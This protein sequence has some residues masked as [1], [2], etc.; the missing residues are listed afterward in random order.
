ML[1]RSRHV[2]IVEE[3]VKMP[4]LTAPVLEVDKSIK[5]FYDFTVDS[6]RLV[7]YKFND[8]KYDIPVAE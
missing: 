4:R 7:D 3:I 6:F 8:K 5:N 2:P 1:F